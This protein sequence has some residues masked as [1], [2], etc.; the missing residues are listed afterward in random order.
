M[1]KFRL[2]SDKNL[3]KIIRKYFGKV[4]VNEREMEMFENNI[5]PGLFR[6]RLEGKHK[7]VYTAPMSKSLVDYMKKGLTVHKLYG[8]LA[9]VVEI[10][11]KIEKYGFYLNNLVLDERLIYV[12]EMTGE[13]I[14]L[15]EPVE[16][17][18]NN[19]NVYAFLA[20]FVRRIKAEEKELQEECEK[21]KAFFSDSSNYRMEDV[22]KYIVKEYPQI[23]QQITR[24]EKENRGKSSKHLEEEGGT[25]L[26]YDE[27]G[28]TLLDD[29]DGTVLLTEV[30]Q[31][32]KLYRLKNSTMAEINGYEFHIGKS[33]SCDFCISDNKAISRNHAVILCRGSEYFLRDEN[34]TNHTYVNGMMLE[35]GTE[36]ELQSGDKIRLADEEFEFYL[37]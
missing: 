34:S 25:T 9:Q 15:Y 23:Y 11:K 17:R 4:P 7:I 26:L 1:S 14:F 10:T 28:T 37:E 32:P 8:I 19:T 27:D 3:I 24:I 35:G 2:A 21:L 36:K 20:D 31:K 12:R 29:E 13:L 30:R 6:P 5:L 33:I 22:E 18:D 16:S